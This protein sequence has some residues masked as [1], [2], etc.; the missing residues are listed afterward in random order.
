MDE[1]LKRVDA[2]IAE[3]A[4]RQKTAGLDRR[5]LTDRRLEAKPV[6]TDNR[7]ADRRQ[8]VD[9]RKTSRRAPP[10]RANYAS[11]AEYDRAYDSWSMAHGV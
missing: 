2:Q 9:R 11:Q 1:I 3:R 4:E 6:E 8:V 10:N 7:V 5:Q